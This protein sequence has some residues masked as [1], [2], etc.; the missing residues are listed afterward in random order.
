MH[1]ILSG[2]GKV[3]QE[4]AGRNIQSE[5]G[6]E[7]H[8][9]RQE[10]GGG[11]PV[12]CTLHE[13]AQGI[14]RETA[15]GFETS[16]VHHRAWRA[17]SGGGSVFL[18]SQRRDMM[19]SMSSSCT[20][21]LGGGGIRELGGSTPT[22]KSPHKEKFLQRRRRRRKT[23]NKKSA[24]AP[25]MREGLEG[26]VGPPPTRNGVVNP[27][28]THRVWGFLCSPGGLTRGASCSTVDAEIHGDLEK[29]TEASETT[30]EIPKQAIGGGC[31]KAIPDHAS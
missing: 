1:G 20:G 2:R 18:T 15:E 17:T 12:W 16:Q 13:A 24:K 3:T 9:A 31:P 21:K 5:G 8:N 10:G 28:T 6:R 25:E 26:G 7:R 14:K 19:G 23:L 4:Q 11:C 30:L 27:P 29:A 22:N